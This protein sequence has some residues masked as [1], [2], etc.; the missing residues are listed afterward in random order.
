LDLFEFFYQDAIDF[1]LICDY[2]IITYLDVV[3][4][5]SVSLSKGVVLEDSL[6]KVE[7][8]FTLC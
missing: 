3:D 6:E 8:F 1:I 5:T 7:G 4:Y 2:L